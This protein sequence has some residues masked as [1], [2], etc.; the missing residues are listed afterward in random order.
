[1]RALNKAPRPVGS[2]LLVIG[3]GTIGLL[4]VQVA[5][6]SGFGNI[7]AVDTKE[8]RRDLALRL[9]ADLAPAPEEL[10]EVLPEATGGIG[11]DVVVECSGVQGLAR[12]AIRLSRRGG[13]TVLVGIH[14]RDEPFDLLEAVLHEKHIV[15]SAAHLWDEDV[16]V[17][18]DLL[19]RG[20]VDGRPLLTRRVQLE[21]IVEE[22]F[23]VLEDPGDVLKILITPRFE[24]TRRHQKS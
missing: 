21:E 12:E 7:V 3:A 13:T 9:G 6:A 18:V 14:G 8:R 10:E 1:V 19:A 11:P 22:G 15:G 4:V 20:H 24:P 5:R 2:S 16:A 17:A 23:K